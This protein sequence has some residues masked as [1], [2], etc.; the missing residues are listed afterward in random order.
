M[1]LSASRQV[2]HQ[3]G[4]GSPAC[5]NWQLASLLVPKQVKEGPSPQDPRSHSVEKAGDGE[6]SKTPS[7]FLPPL[8]TS[9]PPLVSQS[10]GSFLPGLGFQEISSTMAWMLCLIQTLTL[11]SLLFPRPL[12]TPVL[13]LL[14]PLGL[15]LQLGQLGVQLLRL[16]LYL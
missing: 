4:S 2:H 7:P 9:Q 11:S 16:S 8:P 1:P 12:H 3:P 14:V 13:L 10:S 15:L 5:Y 6:L